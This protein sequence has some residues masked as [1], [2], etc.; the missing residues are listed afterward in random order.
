VI[1]VSIRKKDIK[2]SSNFKF[3]LINLYGCSFIK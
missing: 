1:D 2:K 3:F